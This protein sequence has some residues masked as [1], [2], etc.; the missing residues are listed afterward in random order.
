MKI[1]EYKKKSV[2][3][4]TFITRAILIALALAVWSFLLCGCSARDSGLYRVSVEAGGAQSADVG[5]EGSDP[6]AGLQSGESGTDSGTE[7]VDNGGTETV[8]NGGTDGSGSDPK[9]GLQSDES[10][11]DNGTDESEDLHVFVHVCGAVKEPGVYEMDPEDRVYNA[12]DAA[13][14]FTDEAATDYVN[15]AM[16]ISDGMKLDIPTA[17]EVEALEEA[18]I[19]A[20]EYRGNAPAAAESPGLININT[21]D[22]TALMG[23]TGIGET[24]AEAIIAYREAHGNFGSIEDIK[25]VTGIGDST[26]NKFKDEITVGSK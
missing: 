1:I 15:L 5:L 8:D 14:G 16:V 7:T 17:D 23:I 9:A 11:L 13:G 18:G 19:S 3:L 10:G 6:K 20:V 21:A 2:H 25:N 24:K 22:K 26:Y 12:I 4:Y